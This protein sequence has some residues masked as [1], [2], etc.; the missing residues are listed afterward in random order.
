MSVFS[1]VTVSPGWIV[2]V[3]GMK[4]LLVSSQPGIPEPGEFATVASANA[5][6]IAKNPTRKITRIT[7]KNIFCVIIYFDYL[8]NKS[9]LMQ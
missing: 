9:D 4:Q 6:G 1:Q 7:G 2:T 3:L 8:T 5:C